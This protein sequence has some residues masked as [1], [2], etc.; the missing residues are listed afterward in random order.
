[1]QVI[2]IDFGDKRIGIA[3]GD[4]GIGLAIPQDVY[5]NHSTSDA[6]GYIIGKAEETNAQVIVVGVPYSMSGKVGPQA[7]L[8]ISFIEILQSQTRLPVEMV[9]ERLS[10]SIVH[11]IVEQRLNK[12]RTRKKKFAIK[13]DEVDSS[14]AA[15]I[16]QSWMD[17]RTIN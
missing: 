13:T 2:G 17:S 7:E 4:T 15:V 9:D 16:L 6:A 5:I 1:M 10:T 11:K 3:I 14:S 8:V 12:K